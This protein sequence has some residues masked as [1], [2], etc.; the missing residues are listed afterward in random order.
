MLAAWVIA[1]TAFL[2]CAT[3]YVQQARQHHLTTARPPDPITPVTL[4]SVGVIF[5]IIVVISSSYEWPVRLASAAAGALAAPMIFEFPFDLIVMARTYPPI[6]PDPA[7]YRILF[8]APL[9]LI[10]T[11]TVSLLTLS[12]MVKL[13]R[14]GFVSFAAMLAVFAVWGLAGF[15]YPSEPI[16]YAL[17]VASKIL[18][19][20]TA[21]SLFLPQRVNASAPFRWL[22]PR[23]VRHTAGPSRSRRLR[24]RTGPAP[25]SGSELR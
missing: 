10:E 20:V 23:A 24:S 8:F 18:A 21:L 25:L 14:A 15:G 6:P 17:N 3:A 19:F 12:P 22:P 4:I 1:I 7:L 9:F 11:T 13:S 2:A 5:L 16:S